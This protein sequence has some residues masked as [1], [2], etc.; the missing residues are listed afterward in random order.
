MKTLYRL[1]FY[2]FAMLVY[3]TF[4]PQHRFGD[5]KGSS[6]MFAYIG[7]LPLFYV[8]ERRLSELVVPSAALLPRFRGSIRN[9]VYGRG[10]TESSEAAGGG[11]VIEGRPCLS[12]RET[13]NT[14]VWRPR[15][16]SSRG[17]TD[18]DEPCDVRDPCHR[19]G[20][21]CLTMDG[22]R[23]GCDCSVRIN[24]SYHETGK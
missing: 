11:D 22:G 12:R 15:V 5:G 20:C 9:V 16:V 13:R 8:S 7:G 1:S 21:L 18:M 24:C 14:I 23:F 19:D 6:G 2:P 10:C 3:L 17:V 4:L